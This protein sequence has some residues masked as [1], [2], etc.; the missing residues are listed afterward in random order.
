MGKGPAAP[1][2]DVLKS[3]CIFTAVACVLASTEGY[4]VEK[5]DGEKILLT[6]MGFRVRMW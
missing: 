1:S 3:N 6:L 4:L 5:A 2:R